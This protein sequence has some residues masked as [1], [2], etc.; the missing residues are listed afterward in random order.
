MTDTH[1]WYSGARFFNLGTSHPGTRN[2]KMSKFARSVIL[3]SC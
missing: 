3:A 1:I 2:F